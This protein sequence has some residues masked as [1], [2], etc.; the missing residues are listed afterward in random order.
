MTLRERRRAV[1][2]RGPGGLS[3][4]ARR[5]ATDAERAPAFGRRSR[6]MTPEQEDVTRRIRQRQRG[7]SRALMLVLLTMAGLFYAISM[8]RMAERGTIAPSAGRALPR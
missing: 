5:R 1:R 2:T 3:Q 8:V 7:R 6:L 4:H